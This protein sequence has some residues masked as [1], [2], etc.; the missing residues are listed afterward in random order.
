MATD[1]TAAQFLDTLA[2]IELQELG[3]PGLII[4]AGYNIKA[5]FGHQTPTNIAG[6]YACILGWVTSWKWGPESARG[7][8]QTIEYGGHGQADQPGAWWGYYKVRRYIVVGPATEQ[9]E[10]SLDKAM[11]WI[12]LYRNAVLKHTKLN[13]TVLKCTPLGG[14][15]QA[16]PIGGQM[17]RAIANDLEIITISN[18]VVLP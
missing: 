11:T 17:Y 15:I 9:L 5:T 18:P 13:N 8:A 2:A 7:Q 6:Q 14:Q 3:N 4:E 1:A 16:L 12:E 10:I